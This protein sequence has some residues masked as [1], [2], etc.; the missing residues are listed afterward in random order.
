MN[1]LKILFGF[2]IFLSSFI[3]KA[4]ELYCELDANTPADFSFHIPRATSVVL[5]QV[6]N[7]SIKSFSNEEIRKVDKK[8]LYYSIDFKNG[9]SAYL[10]RESL[11]L[12]YLN[13]SMVRAKMGSYYGNSRWAG[14]DYK[15]RIV[16]RKI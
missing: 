13:S 5:I 15:C 12:V 7:E 10:H 3:A 4:T 2:S 1:F 16:I 8:T 9:G 14:A 6:K 11:D